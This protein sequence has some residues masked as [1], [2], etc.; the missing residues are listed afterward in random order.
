MSLCTRPAMLTIL[1][2]LLAL[3]G[4][5]GCSHEAPRTYQEAYEQKLYPEALDKASLV[6]T[7]E[8]AKD[9]QRAAL[10]AGMSAQSLGQYA[11]A[12]KWLIPLKMSPDRDI[13]ARARASLGLI[14]KA[15]G[16]PAEAATLLTASAD[17]LSGDDAAQ[18]KIN[19]GDA[20]RQMGLEK[21]AR[22]EYN[23]AKTEA[24]DPSLKAAADQKAKPTAYYIQCGAF[25]TRQAADR[26]VKTITPQ[27]SK[28]SQPLPTVVQMNPNGTP[29]FVVQVG[30]YKDKS[31][32][33]TAK[34]R[35]NLQTAAII[36]R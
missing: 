22:E 25:S 2:S 19:A 14:A 5:G 21:Q 31:L 28:A 27:A 11:E 32:A 18:A 26:Q 33:M 3:L 35:M 9:R 1:L 29:L 7:D 6:A 34:A 8:H 17:Q 36:S 10:I 16:K 23:G 12:K 4:L 20:Y 30:P 15:E 13:A 24:D